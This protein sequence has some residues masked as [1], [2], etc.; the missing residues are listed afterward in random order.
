[1]INTLP[2]PPAC[3]S[4]AAIVGNRMAV[5]WIAN[6]SHPQPG[7]RVVVA[8]TR[9][10]AAGTARDPTQPLRVK[11]QTCKQGK[12]AL[13]DVAGIRSSRKV[14]IQ[15]VVGRGRIEDARGRILLSV[16]AMAT[17]TAA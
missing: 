12:Q 13:W 7:E 3:R 9:L 6:Q 15:V 14:G 8:S 10:Q 16:P 4:E 5:S 1:L 17:A 11:L 2:A